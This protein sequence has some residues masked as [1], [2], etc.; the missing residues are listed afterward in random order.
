M[1]QTTEPS[2]KCCAAARANRKLLAV[3]S[4]VF[5]AFCWLS[6]VYALAVITLNWM[7]IAHTTSPDPASAVRAGIAGTIYQLLTGSVLACV[8]M[9]L[10]QITKLLL[11]SAPQTP[12][13]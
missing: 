12:A 9:W 1:E 11:E 4:C 8:F 10:S 6:V 13:P 7:A 3:F 5:A 2:A